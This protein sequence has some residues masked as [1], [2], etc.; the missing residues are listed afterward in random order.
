M[1]PGGS[2]HPWGVPAAPQGHC[3][4]GAGGLPYALPFMSTHIHTNLDHPHT[5]CRHCSATADGRL[6]PLFTRV[7]FQG[8]R[9]CGWCMQAGGKQGLI[10]GWERRLERIAKT[11]GEA[12]AEIARLGFLAGILVP[13][14]AEQLSNSFVKHS[15][16]IMYIISGPFPGQ[17]LLGQTAASHRPALAGPRAM[18]AVRCRASLALQRNEREELAA[19]V[20]EVGAAGRDGHSGA[21][22]QLRGAAQGAGER[23][24]VLGSQQFADGP[25]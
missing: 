1:Q 11:N 5:K 7:P 4:I 8:R 14:E 2:R 6:C 18:H 23:E 20:G 19:R 13:Q 24:W 16:H 22:L 12:F 15:N 21:G 10:L 3:G 25:G 9:I 17:A